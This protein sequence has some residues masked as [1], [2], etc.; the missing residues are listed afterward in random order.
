MFKFNTGT[1]NGS[2]SISFTKYPIIF[3]V[4]AL[5]LLFSVSCGPS[6]E[7]RT[8][9]EDDEVIVEKAAEEEEVDKPVLEVLEMPEWHNP[10]QPFKITADSV[11]I[12]AS[13]VS[14]DSADA[15][16]IAE[17]AVR[18]K[19]REAFTDMIFQKLE[20]D[21]T[22]S[23][24][25]DSDLQASPEAIQIFLSTKDLGASVMESASHSH[26]NIFY[27]REG[28]QVRCYIRYAYEKTVLESAIRE[29]ADQL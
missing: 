21:G 1:M 2:I 13:A 17:I 15:R 28:D 11:L 29:A 16:I 18:D 14:S 7:L 4:L 8:D 23:S 25:P 10:S 3:F 19:K 12:S 26:E 27:F 20:N 5:S 24:V 9:E 22:I 6:S